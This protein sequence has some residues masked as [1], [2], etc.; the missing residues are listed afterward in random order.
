MANSIQSI[1]AENKCNQCTKPLL[2]KNRMLNIV[3]LLL[4]SLVYHQMSYKLL[5]IS[6][7][8]RM[9]WISK[10][11]FI[12]MVWTTPLI[13][14]LKMPMQLLKPYNRL[15][16]IQVSNQQIQ[17]IFKLPKISYYNYPMRILVIKSKQML[18]Q[19]LLMTLLP[20]YKHLQ[21]TEKWEVLTQILMLIRCLLMIQILRQKN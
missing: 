18:I 17:T 9:K 11:N 20:M 1:L 4:G 7:K 14:L 16:L 2:L 13:R 5:K 6:C 12:R 8:L 15:R 21:Q 19:L 10:H 3:L